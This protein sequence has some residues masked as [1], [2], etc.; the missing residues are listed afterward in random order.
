MLTILFLAFMALTWCKLDRDMD[1][2]TKCIPAY[3]EV[4]WCNLFCNHIIRTYISGTDV[5]NTVHSYFPKQFV[6]SHSY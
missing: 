1:M 2:L 4:Y 5:S 6:D 3:V